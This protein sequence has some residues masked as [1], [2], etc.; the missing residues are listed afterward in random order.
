MRYGLKQST[1]D[2]INGVLVNYPAVEKVILYG[3]RAKG[4]YRNG[5]DIDLTIK[6]GRVKIEDLFRIKS[7]FDDFLLPY[8]IDLSVYDK[9]NHAGLIDHI[10][11]SG[12]LFYERLASHTNSEKI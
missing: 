7:E 3:S 11:H 4:T 5:S 1:I 10:D 8:D 6:G 2:L 9:I 12:M